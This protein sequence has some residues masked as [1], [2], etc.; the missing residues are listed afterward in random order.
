M[1]QPLDRRTLL[2]TCG[3]ALALP[4]LEAMSPALARAAIPAPRRMVTLCNALGLHPPA[5]F[6]AT[7]G[8]DYETTEYLELLRDHRRDYTLFSG[9][10]HDDQTGR[11][12]HSSEVTWL[13]G[14]RHPE[15]AGFRNSISADQY[16][17]A[18]LGYVTRFPSLVLGTDTT[19][20]RSAKGTQSQSFTRR[21]VMVP[22]ETSPANLF[23]RMF[24]TGDADEVERQ[25]RD[26]GDGRSILDGL[27]SQR[28]ALDRRASAADRGRLDSYFEAVRAA[29]EGITE[30]QAWLERPKPRVDRE[31]PV[32]IRE[33]RDLIGRVQLLMDL[34]PLIL[35]TDS[36]RVVAVMI[37]ELR[38]VP[39]IP[40]VSGTHH[41]LSH[42]GQDP[43]KIAQLRKV[44]REI[45]KCFGSLLGQLKGCSEGDGTLL[46]QTA[47]LFGSN[48]GNANS[49]DTRNLPVFLAGG[50]FEH[51]RYVA[52][53]NDD[54]APLSNLYVTML[55]H[56]GLETGSFGQST[57]A[58]S[59]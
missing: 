17:A 55:N 23:A 25:K 59:W 6:P 31:P 36:T 1:N 39:K 35:Q 43:D 2:R 40:G 3:V 51:G 29:E 50:G 10:S 42:H 15:L 32:D 57:G 30:A 11:Q 22:S 21:G 49:H 41:N 27:R 34:I 28:K 54:N 48:L 24:L 18:E 53:D 45:V 44:E 38:E 52:L 4:L 8:R 19:L 58:L 46:D 37:Q 47:V 7:P 5:L 26:L 16:A 56:M 33:R 9:L 20:Q 14:A 13:T 12:A